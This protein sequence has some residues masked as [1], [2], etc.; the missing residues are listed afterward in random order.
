[1]NV[2]LLPALV[3]LLAATAC[4]GNDLREVLP[5]DV[6]RTARIDVSPGVTIHVVRT[7]W[8]GIKEP[9]WRYR[10]PGLL[11]VPRLFLSRSWHEWLP[12]LSYAVVTPDGTLLVDTGADPALERPGAMACDPNSQ[13]FY[14][15]NLRFLAEEAETVD[16]QLAALGIDPSAVDRIVVTHFHADHVGRL[17]AFPGWVADYVTV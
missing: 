1:M 10:A 9:H 8:V 2:R 11:V 13:F 4:S 16:R 12:N 5:P 15:A 14:E 17:D 3:A 7:G 6:P